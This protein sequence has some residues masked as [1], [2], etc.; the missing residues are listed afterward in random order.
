VQAVVTHLECL[1][2][3]DVKFV[4]HMLHMPFSTDLRLLLEYDAWLGSEGNRHKACAG[5][6]IASNGLLQSQVTVPGP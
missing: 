2:Y 3:S 4:S 1:C 5:N 6:V